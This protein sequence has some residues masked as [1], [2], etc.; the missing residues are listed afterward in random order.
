MS[1]AVAR[2]LN[3]FVGR[4]LPERRIFI[5]SEASTRYLHLSPLGQLGGIAVVVAGLGLAGHS[6]LAM[7]DTRMERERLLLDRVAIERAFAER[8]AALQA[9]L[10]AA[11]TRADEAEADYRRAQAA[12]AETQDE[13]VAALADLR[14]AEVERAHLSDRV[15]ALTMERDAARARFSDLESSLRETQLKLLATGFEPAETAGAPAALPAGLL[16]AAMADVISER[17]DALARAAELDAEVD[18][19]AAALTGARDRQELLFERIEDAVRVGLDGLE[20]VLKEA[21]LDIDAILA[22]T[23]SSHSGTGGP[24]EPVPASLGDEAGPRLAAIMHDIER[25]NTMR[26]AMDRLPFGRPVTGVRQTSGF[27]RRIDPFRKRWS[28]HNGVD[29]AGP[30]GTP[31]KA[32]AEGVVTFSGW[33]SGYGRVIEIRHAFGYE[34]RYAHL[35]RMSVEVGDRVERGDVIGKMGS[36]GRSTGSHLHYEVRI[37]GS[38]IDPAKFIEAARDVL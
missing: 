24:F 30:V 35:S 23:R 4:V 33:M 2:S 26:V 34:T 27:G 14:A 21:D 13:I 38:A 11:S 31:I 19:L 3:G 15:A 12:L 20:G 32:T 16:S 18:R 7:L 28:M 25:M 5:R 9:E 8:F 6:T 22:E 17:D 29:W 1:N 10:D 37:G 36:S